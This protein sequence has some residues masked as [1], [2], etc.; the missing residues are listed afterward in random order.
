MCHFRHNIYPFVIYRCESFMLLPAV[1][2]PTEILTEPNAFHRA[3]N[4]HSLPGVS[5]RFT[6]NPGAEPRELSSDKLHLALGRTYHHRSGYV[7]INVKMGLIF[8][9]LW[10]FNIFLEGI[11]CQGVYGKSTHFL[12]TQQLS[13]IPPT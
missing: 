9:L 6:V 10:L 3:S 5:T 2:A 7:D 4:K 12:N 11:H 1:P 8:G 13:L